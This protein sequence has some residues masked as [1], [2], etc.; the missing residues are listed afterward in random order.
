M[1][2]GANSEG[3]EI[4][5]SSSAEFLKLLQALMAES[6]PLSVGG[7]C[8]GAAD[9][10]ELLMANGE[11]DG[12]YVQIAWRGPQKYGVRHDKIHISPS[13]NSAC[14]LNHQLYIRH[15]HILIRFK[16]ISGANPLW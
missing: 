1:L 7:H 2:A 14:V 13:S 8:I 6:V 3:L 10:V 4:P 12:S 5:F 11:L 9:E 15:T 16:S